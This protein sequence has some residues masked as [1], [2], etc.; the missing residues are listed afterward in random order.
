MKYA[1]F[2]FFSRINFMLLLKIR[3][4]TEMLACI[5]NTF[6]SYVLKI[7]DR[8]RMEHAASAVEQHQEILELQVLYNI[9]E[10]RNEAVRLG[11]WNEDH[12]GK[13]NFL[14]NLLCNEYDWEVEQVE[15]YLYEVIE[16]GPAV[17]KES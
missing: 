1:L 7:I 15:R 8:D 11:Q 2:V 3:S 14:G 10:V 6:T 12:E 5:A 4:T 17:N 13:L 9:F 16:T